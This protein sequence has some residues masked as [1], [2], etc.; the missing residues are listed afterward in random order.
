M[1]WLTIT[2]KNNSKFKLYTCH[3]SVSVYMLVLA[4]F[5]LTYLLPESPCCQKAQSYNLSYHD[6]LGWNSN[7]LMVS[8]AEISRQAYACCNNILK[9]EIRASYLFPLLYIWRE[10]F[11]IGEPVRV[12]EILKDRRCH[13]Q[14]SPDFCHSESTVSQVGWQ[15]CLGSF[16]SCSDNSKHGSRAQRT[17]PSHQMT[18]GTRINEEHL[19]FGCLAKATH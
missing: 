7:P 6:R 19:S 15:Y 17:G 16:I 4:A 1:I 13:L 2:V 10:L 5:S 11:V 9:G 18:S 3:Q 14:T 12:P 8:W